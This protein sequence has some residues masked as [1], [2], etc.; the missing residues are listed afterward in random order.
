MSE[1]TVQDVVSRMLR[2]AD[3]CRA[4]GNSE[5]AQ[6][7]VDLATQASL[8]STVDE[9][10]NFE[11]M[12]LACARPKKK[13]VGFFRRWFGGGAEIEPVVSHESAIIS[14]D[15]FTAPI[16]SLSQPLF[17]QMHPGSGASGGAGATDT[18]KDL[19]AEANDNS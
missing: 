8:A 11:R 1:L 5:N 4:T 10:M 13:K 17:E 15:Y 18:F 14:A 3:R 6:L 19:P 2:Y 16:E 7:A 9:A 12:L